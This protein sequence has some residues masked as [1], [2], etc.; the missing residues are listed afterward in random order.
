MGGSGTCNA[1]VT[2]ARAGAA[3]ADYALKVAKPAP[4]ARELSRVKAFVLTPAN[5]TGGFSPDWVTRVLRNAMV[6]Y[7]TLRVKN[8]DRLQATLTLVEFMRFT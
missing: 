1:S 7:F 5:R 3:A 8:G 6:P 2:G 4:D